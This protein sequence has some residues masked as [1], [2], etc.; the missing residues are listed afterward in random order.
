M[1]EKQTVIVTGGSGFIGANL[2]RLLVGAGSYRVLNLDLLTYA[3][4]PLSL[5]GL[6]KEPNYIFV[7]GSIADR[8]LADSLLKQYQPVGVFHL[9]AESHVDRSI[10]NA[11]DF[12][13][14]NVAGTYSLLQ[15]CRVYWEV[16]T[17]DRQKTFRF[18]HVSTDEVF[19]SLGEQGYFSEQT[20]YAPNSPYSA[21]KAASD[22]FVRAYHHTYGLPTLIT[23]CSNNYG[24]YQFP[25]KMIPLMILNALTG[26]P[27]PVYG[28]G[29]NV[30][31]W[32]YVGDH[33]RALQLVFEKGTP[34]EV[35][36]IGADNE[37][38]NLDLIHQI[39]IIL[40]ELA[41][42]AEN[43]AFRDKNMNSYMELIRFVT[44]RPGHDQRY[45]I[46][47][48]RIKRELGWKPLQDSKSGLRKTI[49]WYLSNPEW[50]KQAQGG[51][52]QDWLE[53]NYAWRAH[54]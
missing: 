5:A 47:A 16:L 12:V 8:E 36:V 19:G 30:R 29:S 3:A 54:K 26:Q 50:I 43:P 38:K 44:D 10:V 22:H 35:Y 4:N 13:H 37:Q 52:Y 25:E 9:A 24:P 28:D 18:V 1:I 20:P 39:C 49:E 2:V 45:A 46:D 31:D 33:C 42:V 48:G 34:G 53:K 27:L 6:E 7:Q 23:N 15:A 51:S 40:D 14:T 21:S 41:P 17:A 11:D 32:I